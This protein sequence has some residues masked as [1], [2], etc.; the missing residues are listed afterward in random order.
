[1]VLLQKSTLEK[2]RDIL[3]LH[4]CDSKCR[5]VHITSFLFG[6]GRNQRSHLGSWISSFWRLLLFA[7]PTETPETCSVMQAMIR[8]YIWGVTGNSQILGAKMWFT[9]C[10][11][12]EISKFCHLWNSLDLLYF[13]EHDAHITQR[14]VAGTTRLRKNEVEFF[15]SCRNFLL[16]IHGNKTGNWMH[17]DIIVCTTDLTNVSR[18]CRRTL[19][20]SWVSTNLWNREK[21]HCSHCT[22]S[23]HT[24]SMWTMM[25][26]CVEAVRLRK[27]MSWCLDIDCSGL[28]WRDKWMQTRLGWRQRHQLGRNDKKQEVQEVPESKTQS[29]ILSLIYEWLHAKPEGWPLAPV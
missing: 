24:S 23:L 5:F 21:N 22:F 28:T 10:Q 6:L 25:R 14:K 4:S 17:S 16:S 1:M 3:Y 2:P 12:A 18:C 9:K 11:D 29:A 26:Q 27:P 8:C 7:L 13:S 19:T 15:G 20:Q